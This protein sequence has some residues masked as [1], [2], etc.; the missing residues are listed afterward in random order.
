[1]WSYAITDNGPCGICSFLL[2]HRT[3]L[4]RSEKSWLWSYRNITP[5]GEQYI[6]IANEDRGT[7]ITSCCCQYRSFENIERYKGWGGL[8]GKIERNAVFP[9]RKI[10]EVCVTIKHITQKCIFTKT[11][12]RTSVGMFWNDGHMLEK[13]NYWNRFEMLSDISRLHWL[14]SA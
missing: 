14:R 10:V 8:L 5:T 1:M 3:G 13:G 11:V 9:C 4:Y 6:T 12:W 2:F 7:P